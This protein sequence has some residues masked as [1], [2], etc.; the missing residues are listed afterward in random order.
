MEHDGDIISATIAQRFYSTNDTSQC[1][2]TKASDLVG[3]VLSMEDADITYDFS[4]LWN[5]F[6][7]LKCNKLSME[8]KR[9]QAENINLLQKELC[10]LCIRERANH[11]IIPC[12]HMPIGGKCMQSQPPSSCPICAGPI[13][14]TIKI[15][16]S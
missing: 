14:R 5:F 16:R 11:V 10:Q 1:V 13:E 7:N 4:G 6:S 8:A 2:H 3:E 12:G 9:I 15:F